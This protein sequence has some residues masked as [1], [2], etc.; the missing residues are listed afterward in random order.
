MDTNKDNQEL[1]NFCIRKLVYPPKAVTLNCY[2]CGVLFCGQCCDEIHKQLEFRSHNVCLASAEMNDRDTT[3]FQQPSNYSPTSSNK[4]SG[5]PMLKRYSS[6]LDL[7]PGITMLS[8]IF[9]AKTFFKPD[10]QMRKEL[11]FVI[12]AHK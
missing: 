2:D 11:F 6:S 8:L 4:S 5:R 7:I 10:I 1:C 9:K 12:Y 3:S